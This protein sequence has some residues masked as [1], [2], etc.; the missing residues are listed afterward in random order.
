MLD[1]CKSLLSHPSL[2][3]WFHCGGLLSQLFMADLLTCSCIFPSGC[4]VHWISIW[5]NCQSSSSQSS[6]VGAFLWF[7]RPSILQLMNLGM[8]WC[9]LWRVLFVM[10]CYVSELINSDDMISVKNLGFSFLSSVQTILQKPG[11]RLLSKHMF[12]PN[13]WKM[14]FILLVIS[15]HITD[16]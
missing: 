11:P 1:I 8:E 9:F 13:A 14:L 2:F 16:M 3:Y 10:A 6:E 12:R 7:F 5:P 4:R 15:Y